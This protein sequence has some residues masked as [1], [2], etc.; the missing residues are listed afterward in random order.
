MSKRVTLLY[1]K[2]V[3]KDIPPCMLTEGYCSNARHMSFE[4]GIAQKMQGYT[5]YYNTADDHPINGVW[6]FRGSDNEVYI[7]SGTKHNMSKIVGSTG[8]KGSLKD[9]YTGLDI[10]TVTADATPWSFANFGSVLLF[11]NGVDAVQTFGISNYTSVADL[12]GT[13]IKA[14]AVRVH[15]RHVFLLGQSA[16]LRRA[17]WSDIDDYTTWT[18]AADNEAGYQDIFESKTPVIGGDGLGDYFVVYTGSMINVFQYTGGTFVYGRRIADWNVGL[19][20]KNLIANSKSAHFFM[21][22]YN[23][24][25]FDGTRAV[26]I[27]DGIKK[28]VWASLV[29]A[30][31]SKAF[32][33]TNELRGEAH[34]VLPIASGAPSLDCIYNWRN[35]AWSFDD[36][37]WWAGI[38]RTEILYP[39]VTYGGAV[40]ATNNKIYTI[41][42]T[43][44]DAAGG[45]MTGYVDSAEQGSD[46]PETMKVIDTIQPVI[47]TTSAWAAGAHVH[48]KIGFRNDVNT[49]V[50]WSSAYDLHP[51]ATTA[52]R[53]IN[54]RDAGSG[55]FWRIKV[56]TDE[57]TTPFMIAKIHCEVDAAGS[58]A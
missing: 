19:W 11:T 41:D 55:R 35:G 6:V 56:Y 2:G 42:I 3:I 22:Q 1:T 21:S 38:D 13:T 30:Q 24:Y 12:V 52:E 51:N 7:M 50:T 27:G 58:R 46:D 44:A 25:V 36:V 34:F 28:D 33:F 53:K 54:T 32:A 10:A 16:N 49:A 31:I 8:V 47:Q 48:F 40:A 43:D 23:F 5:V 14:N 37:L 29:S 45:V 26:P 39:L 9:D 20:K 4:D 17:T 18:P 57:A 15:Q